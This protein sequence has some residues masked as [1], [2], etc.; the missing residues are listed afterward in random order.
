MEHKELSIIEDKIKY[1]TDIEYGV[2]NKII[3]FWNRCKKL[4][5]INNFSLN[6]EKNEWK[7]EIY[8]NEI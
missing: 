2:N 7:L 5:S 1:L 8:N 6:N 3:E 4:A